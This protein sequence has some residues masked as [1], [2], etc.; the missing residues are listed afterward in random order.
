M[1]VRAR[2]CA[3]VRVRA[4]ACVRAHGCA[5]VVGPTGPNQHVIK[6]TACLNAW[7]RACFGISS[8]GGLLIPHLDNH[9][10]NHSALKK[11]QLRGIYP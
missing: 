1:R 3:C 11:H 6:K 9:S 7:I 2:A 8:L 5:Y 10:Q 4:C